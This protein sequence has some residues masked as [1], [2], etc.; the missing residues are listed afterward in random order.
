MAEAASVPA[1]PDSLRE[2]VLACPPI[3][4]TSET[5]PAQMRHVLEAIG[6]LVEIG[7]RA[8]A[9][10]AFSTQ[11]VSLWADGAPELPKKDRSA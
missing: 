3:G 4:L 11:T 5:T 9:T 8:E 2:D 7:E 6:Y 10:V 1:T